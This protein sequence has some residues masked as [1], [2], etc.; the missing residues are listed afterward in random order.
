MLHFDHKTMS[1][2]N[3]S[4][5]FKKKL[6]PRSK[7]RFL[8]FFSK[9]LSSGSIHYYLNNETG[10]NTRLFIHNYFAL[11]NDGPFS[12]TWEV[13]LF[14]REGNLLKTLTGTFS[15]SATEVIDLAS[16]EGLDN[17]GIV[18]VHIRDTDGQEFLSETYGTI[19]FVEYYKPGT[20][21]TAF[22]HGL[23]GFLRP[24]HYT[25][26][27]SSTSWVTPE[28]YRPYLF[29]ANAC[30]FQSWLHPKCGNA[31]VTFIN[32]ENKKK[33]IFIPNMAP[34]SCHKIDLLEQRPDLI[35]HLRGKA[36]V[37]D[38]SGNNVLAKPLIFQTS[39]DLAL[40]E[41]L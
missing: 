34:L 19:F 16:V 26:Q 17:Y 20:D 36:Y 18:G 40:V 15:G 2:N 4:A 32:C 8:S 31:L 35:E 3:P 12:A 33:S 24:T 41:H 23:S 28:T 9:I 38:I 14:S 25:Y 27:H 13:E 39:G 21:Q 5:I 11:L 6:I 29:I 7:N 10:W 22:A 30:R 1:G 37:I